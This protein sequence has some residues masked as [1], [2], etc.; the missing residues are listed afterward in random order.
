MALL[1]LL[2]AEREALLDARRL[3]PVMLLD[4]VMSE[5]DPTRRRLLVEALAGAGQAV[6]TA[7][8]REHVPAAPGLRPIAVR[9]GRTTALAAGDAAARSR[10]R[11]A[12]GG[13]EGGGLMGRRTLASVGRALHDAL[14]PIAPA[15]RSP[16]CRTSG[17]R[18]SAS[19]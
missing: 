5:L 14:A 11:A 13:R 17:R 9:D 6:I 19:A 18:R 2:F 4:D 7:T 10:G 3:A 1:A 16:R 8:E 12:R 15:T